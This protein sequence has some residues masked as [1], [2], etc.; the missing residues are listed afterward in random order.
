MLLQRAFTEGVPAAELKSATAFLLRLLRLEGNES[1]HYDAQA[2]T[3]LETVVARGVAS[4]GSSYKILP[5]GE[6]AFDFICSLI[7]PLVD[8][9]AVHCSVV[10]G[11]KRLIVFLQ[12]LDLLLRSPVDQQG[13]GRKATAGAVRVYWFI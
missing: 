2:Q 7:W 8:A 4:G 1:T 11:R 13:D 10:C 12:V 9:Y 6:R 5:N 3:A